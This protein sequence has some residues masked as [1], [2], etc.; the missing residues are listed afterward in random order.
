MSIAPASSD[1]ITG[2][3]GI[4]LS[5]RGRLLFLGFPVLAALVLSVAAAVFMGVGG[6]SPA[7]ASGER[8]LETVRSVTVGYGDTLWS[9]AGQAAPD[10]P[11]NE[12]IQRIGELNSLRGSELQPGQ[13]LFVPAAG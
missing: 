1:R 8:S 9:I 7:V 5:R 3:A 12:A 11:R 10:V 6:M 4:H 2:S 13:V